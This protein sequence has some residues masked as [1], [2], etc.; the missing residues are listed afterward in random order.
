MAVSFVLPNVEQLINRYELKQVTNPTLVG[1]PEKIPGTLF[2]EDIFGPVGDESRN[3]TFA[4]IDLQNEYI[5][6]AVYDIMKKYIKLLYQGVIGEKR[7]KI[8]DS[9]ELVEDFTEGL[10]GLELMKTIVEKIHNIEINPRLKGLIE[11]FGNNVFI[12]Y[13]IVIPPTFRPIHYVG[14]RPMPDVLN[15]FYAKI[16]SLTTHSLGEE[17][18]V[19]VQEKIWALYDKLKSLLGKKSGLIRSVLLGKRIDF[20]GRGVIS[21]DPTM[22]GDSVGVPYIILAEI[23]MPYIIHTI[24]HDYSEE[25]RE[26]FSRLFE[27]KGLTVNT[28]LIKTLLV[29]FR[30]DMITDNDIVN[31]IKEAIRIAVRDKLVLLKR[32][33]ALHRT[34]WHALKPVPV[35]GKSIRMSFG[36]LGAIGGDFDGDTIGGGDYDVTIL[37]EHDNRYYRYKTKLK[38]L[39]KLTLEEV[40]GQS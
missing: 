28:Q 14:G 8:L 7:I 6:P 25:H 4:Y 17:S 27:A 15:E 26:K 1:N 9:G 33:P 31:Y 16:I 36:V 39:Y 32:D 19:L 23:A 3:T 12:K 38:D 13:L 21:A 35:E 40:V 5:H 30:K 24:L 29:Q 37:V 22:P 2:S 18:F 34:S 11:K 20:S 10:T